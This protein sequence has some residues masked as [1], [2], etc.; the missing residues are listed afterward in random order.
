MNAWLKVY[1]EDSSSIASNALLFY[2][3]MFVALEEIKSKVILDRD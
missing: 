2:A 3:G 1:K